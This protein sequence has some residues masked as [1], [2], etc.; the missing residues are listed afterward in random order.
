MNNG[1]AARPSASQLQQKLQSGDFVVTTEVSPPVSA[2]IAEFIA[3]ALPLKGLATAVNVTD[4]AGAKTHL[5]TL[6]ASHFLLQNGIEPILQMTC[7]DRNRLALQADL[8]G[9][10]ALGLRNVLILSGDNPKVGDQ[11]DT[12]A[13][14]DLDSKAL[15]ATAHRM[16]AEHKLP[17][18]TEI[19]GNTALVLGAADMPI[20]PPPDWNPASLLGKLDAGADFAQTQFCMDMGIVRRY[21]RRLLDLGI[22]QRLPI[23]IGVCPIP[24]GKSARWMKEKLFG[25]IIPDAVVER[26]DA[27]ADAR[28]EG[29]KICVEI[30]RELATIPG[31]AGAHI[32]APVNPSVVPDVIAT[33]AVTGLKRAAV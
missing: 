14:G 29:K 19:K 33:A 30:L 25:T 13:V 18:G 12:K 3:K 9:A 17:P 31:I 11:P 6:V 7:R 2:D 4:G 15:L 27:A 26:L 1:A 10:M 24:S 16:R 32:M 23:L 28:E 22:A 20:D 21:A 5:S 8:M